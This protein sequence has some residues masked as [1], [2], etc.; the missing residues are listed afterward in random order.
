MV[1]VEM[2]HGSSAVLACCSP[3]CLLPFW[4]QG[5]AAG[6]SGSAAE[7][8]RTVLELQLHQAQIRLR[9]VQL[10]TQRRLG[11]VARMRQE[12]REGVCQGLLPA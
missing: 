7:D 8:V 1:C 3:R 12:V 4:L 9:A 10:E 2:V 5:T 6:R 11:S